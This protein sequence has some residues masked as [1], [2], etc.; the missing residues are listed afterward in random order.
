MTEGGIAL[1]RLHTP[2]PQHLLTRALR[3]NHGLSKK[4]KP[5]QKDGD[6]AAVYDRDM[7][8]I[9]AGLREPD[10]KTAVWLIHPTPVSQ[11]VLDFGFEVDKANAS[12]HSQRFFQSVRALKDCMRWTVIASFVY[13]SV[14][15][16]MKDWH[17]RLTD[18]ARMESD[19]KRK[20]LEMALLHT[21]S[22]SSGSGSES[23]GD[24]ESGR[25]S[26]KRK[27]KRRRGGGGRKK[28]RGYRPAV[29]GS[30]QARL[31]AREKEDEEIKTQAMN[32]MAKGFAAMVEDN[33]EFQATV[34]EIEAAFQRG[35]IYDLGLGVIPYGGDD[36]IENLRKW[37]EDGDGPP[38]IVDTR[39]RTGE[40]AWEERRFV[41]AEERRISGAVEGHAQSAFM[42]HRPHSR[43]ET[44][45]TMTTTTSSTIFRGQE[46]YV[47]ET[48]KMPAAVTE[49]FAKY[50]SWIRRRVAKMQLPEYRSVREEYMITYNKGVYA[51]THMIPKERG[52]TRYFP[53]TRLHTFTAHPNTSNGVPRPL[54]L[55]KMQEETQ[56]RFAHNR[57]TLEKINS[58]VKTNI[59]I[60]TVPTSDTLDIIKRQ[61]DNYTD[62]KKDTTKRFEKE[63][64]CTAM[65]TP[66]MMLA[67]KYSAGE[68]VEEAAR[69]RH[70][71]DEIYIRGDARAAH[72]EV[73]TERRLAK[74][75][76][77][78]GIDTDSS[79][80]GEE[81]PGG[82]RREIIGVGG[83]DEGCTLV[84]GEVPRTMTISEARQP[85][86]KQELR[87][88]KQHK[89]TAANT[90]IQKKTAA[91][92]TMLKHALQ[93]K[94]RHNRALVID[95]TRNG[96]HIKDLRIKVQ[97]SDQKMAVQA[98][99]LRE[100]REKNN[101]LEKQLK[102][103]KEI[104]D[105]LAKQITT[106]RK[107]KNFREEDK[108]VILAHVFQNAEKETHRL[109][110]ALNSASSSYSES[111]VENVFKEGIRNF[112]L[113]ISNALGGEALNKMKGP[114]GTFV[115]DMEETWE[116]E[117]GDGV[118]KK[119]SKDTMT[120]YAKYARML[121]EFNVFS[122]PFFEDIAMST[123]NFYLDQ[124]GRE[125]MH[126]RPYAK[127][128]T[129]FSSSSAAGVKSVSLG[130]VLIDDTATMRVININPM[131]AEDEHMLG[132][133]LK[134]LTTTTTHPRSAQMACFASREGGSM[135]IGE[136]SGTIVPPMDTL[137]PRP[138]NSVFLNAQFPKS[139]NMTSVDAT[140]ENAWTI[141]TEHVFSYRKHTVLQNGQRLEKR[142]GVDAVK[143]YPLAFYEC[144]T[145]D[146]SKNDSVSRVVTAVI[147]ASD[148]DAVTLARGAIT[149][150]VLQS[151]FGL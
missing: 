114:L 7:D 41:Y 149:K 35:L 130:G 65:K 43:A 45:R 110:M 131:S 100:S 70:N 78:H 127:K 123:G 146:Y 91:K 23:E 75:L 93:N 136:E 32:D 92:L 40:K 20:E 148:Q 124:L 29:Y 96:L 26:R 16:E 86:T 33:Y 46:A 2:P 27:R 55:G 106:F 122:V 57:Q 98:E 140:L 34:T 60:S 13:K 76:E 126:D 12:P 67:E 11:S 118:T 14:F 15:D 22:A 24:E 137:L 25:W 117:D 77:R 132:E 121:R 115:R 17:E 81:E 105:S 104:M 54:L 145:N 18:V 135:A 50:V 58:C 142:L 99:R 63:T 30:Y 94:D 97:E 89:Q 62:T 61:R 4:N 68:I 53:T 90:V 42:N 52:N 66:A 1:D 59:M 143:A 150:N 74:M 8:N 83:E 101:R 69:H 39:A 31:D 44:R 56:W 120:D 113:G 85:P 139:S 82:E 108:K 95:N 64:A 36:D 79:S 37:E 71:V 151:I 116:R 107:D 87:A 19:R 84:I 125:W 3:E 38:Q 9:M 80:D 103:S 49:C 51:C 10:E 141:L 88:I 133:G 73:A 109:K 128:L 134:D 6:D 112:A 5:P 147:D 47:R 102:Y 72:N 138:V 48:R 21:S 111:A 144:L 119:R 28:G 129:S